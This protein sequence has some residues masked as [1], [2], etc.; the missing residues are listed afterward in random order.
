MLKENHQRATTPLKIQLAYES[1]E[2]ILEAEYYRKFSAK[3]RNSHERHMVR[4]LDG[5]KMLIHDNHDH[6]ATLFLQELLN[7][8]SRNSNFA[9]INRFIIGNNGAQI[10][11]ST[12]P[13]TPLKFQSGNTLV[14]PLT[15]KQIL[16]CERL[17]S[18]V[19][20]DVKFLGKK[21]QRRTILNLLTPENIYFIKESNTFFLGNWL[22]IF[23]KQFE[24]E[25]VAFSLAD[26]EE[27]EQ[28]QLNP[29]KLV[30]KIQVLPFFIQK[31]KKG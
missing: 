17:M 29:Q 11:C 30:T 9:I 25:N 27:S 31:S 13:Y 5:S 7:I 20:I 24:T 19:L 10:I 4:I 12:R 1:F 22:K 21:L 18:D 3:C 28:D 23:E 15:M 14:E 2:P 8:Q 26:S 16:D 6:A